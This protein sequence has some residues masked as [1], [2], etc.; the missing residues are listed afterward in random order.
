[1]Y[2]TD[3]A[4]FGDRYLIIFHCIALYAMLASYTGINS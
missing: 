2:H 3:M 4:G 1:M